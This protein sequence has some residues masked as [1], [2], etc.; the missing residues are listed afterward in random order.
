MK[1]LQ[2]LPKDTCAFSLQF[3][4]IRDSSAAVFLWAFQNFSKYL[5][6][7]HSGLLLLVFLF[8]DE[9]LRQIVE[10]F[11]FNQKAEFKYQ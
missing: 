6:V 2:N 8:T 4:Q 3:Y 1:F 7:G 9:V 5:F 11:S 10:I